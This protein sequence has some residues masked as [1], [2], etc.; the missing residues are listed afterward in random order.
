MKKRQGNIAMQISIM[1]GSVILILVATF[2]Y[3]MFIKPEKLEIN[4]VSYTRINNEDYDVNEDKLNEGLFLTNNF[5]VDNSSVQMHKDL[6]DLYSGRNNPFSEFKDSRE[7][8]ETIDALNKELEDKN[9]Q[10]NKNN[11]KNQVNTDSEEVIY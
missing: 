5:N 11:E 7:D 1:L 10:R 3:Y 2:V 4:E 6:K 8:I 9:N